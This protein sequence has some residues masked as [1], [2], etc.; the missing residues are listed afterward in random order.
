MI[1]A[2]K[3]ERRLLSLSLAKLDICARDTIEMGPLTKI[4]KYK[5]K[6][7]RSLIICVCSEF[8]QETREWID[9]DIGGLG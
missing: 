3:S 7:A 6:L 4:E 5:L 2:L 1:D 9:R 8:N